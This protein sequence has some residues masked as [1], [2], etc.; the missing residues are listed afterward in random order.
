MPIKMDTTCEISSL[1]R[2]KPEGIKQ[3]TDEIAAIESLKE[4]LTHLGYSMGEIDYLIQSRV[5]KPTTGRPSLAD[6]VRI[7]KVLEAQ[8]EFAQKCKEIV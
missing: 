8:L 2:D 7:K 6:L 1:A 4:K 5:Q 3:N